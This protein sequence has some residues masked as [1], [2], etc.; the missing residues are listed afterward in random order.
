LPAA[1]GPR[2]LRLRDRRPATRARRPRGARRDR[3]RGRPRAPPAR[4][5][6]A[7]DRRA[8][9]TRAAG[10]RRLRP[11]WARGAAG[12]PA[13]RLRR[14]GLRSPGRCGTAA[15]LARAPGRCVRPDAGKDPEAA[16]MSATV[17][18][19]AYA[20][21]EAVTRTEAAN[22]YYGIRLLPR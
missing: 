20:H 1:R 2:P 13:R 7:A 3:V 4:R 9:R 6:H 17:L 14:A 22:F 18:D 8:R 10:G 5:R 19:T 15:R 16:R 11:G 21:C 12:D